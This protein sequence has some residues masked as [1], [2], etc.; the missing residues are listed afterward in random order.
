MAMLELCARLG[1]VAGRDLHLF[2]LSPQL[3]PAGDRDPARNDPAR[4]L[5]HLTQAFA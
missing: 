3:T 1:V 2:G 5:V 4:D